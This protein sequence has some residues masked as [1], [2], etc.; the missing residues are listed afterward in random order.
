MNIYV[1]GLIWVV[2]AALA[3][4]IVAYLIR[5]FGATEGTVENN[6]AAGQVFTI[7]GGLH[8]VLLAFVLISLFDAT[9]ATEEQVYREADSLVAANW[10]ADSLG[11]PTSSEI[12]DLS[13]TYVSTVVDKEWPDLEEGKD[14]VA[15]DGWATLDKMRKVISQAQT[16]GDWQND[17]KTEAAN[18]LWDVYEARQE[19]LNAAGNGVSDVVW[20]ALVAGSIMSISLPLLFGGP[21]PVTHIIIV[22]IL[23]GTLSLLLFATHQLQNPF[24][25]GAKIDPAAFESVQARLL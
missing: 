2:G 18:K 13:A 7:V 25:G 8:A 1:S 14:E 21:R 19:R 17:Q 10:A 5:R 9:S 11:E 24:S 3:T 6:E 16:D 22:S 15:G 4:A 23:A 12:R 20:F